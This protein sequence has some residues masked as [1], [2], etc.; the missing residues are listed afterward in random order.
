MSAGY[1]AE[2]DPERILTE[3]PIGEPF[4]AGAARMSDDELRA[5]QERR[6][7]A[8]MRRG[9]EIPFYRRHWGKARL[10]LFG[11]AVVNF[12]AMGRHA[13]RKGVEILAGKRAGDIPIEESPD[14]AIV[15]NVK[16]ARDL[17]IEIPVRVLPPRTPSTRT[18]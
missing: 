9:W 14:Y 8:L 6:F 7:T 13:G 5:L 17:G 16:R 12:G 2:A 4:L 3:Y 18:T 10:G 1:F 15:F 11:G